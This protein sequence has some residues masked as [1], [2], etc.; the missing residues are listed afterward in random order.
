MPSIQDCTSQEHSLLG[1]K[2]GAAPHKVHLAY[3][4]MAKAVLTM[5]G[6]NCHNSRMPAL[7]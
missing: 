1:D 7:R 2:A 3:T 4:E 6:V 5:T